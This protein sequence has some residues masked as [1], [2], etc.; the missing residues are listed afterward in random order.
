MIEETWP[1]GCTI[2]LKVDPLKDALTAAHIT[3]ATVPA[4]V[5]DAE[6][7]TVSGDEPISLPYIEATDSQYAG[8]WTPSPPLTE[9][10]YYTAEYTIVSGDFTLVIHQRRKAAYEQEA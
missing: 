5:T 8:K 1:I 10:A 6:G 9:D 4:V 7:V 2:L 3:T